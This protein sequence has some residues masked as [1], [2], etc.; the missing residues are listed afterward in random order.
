MMNCSA[1]VPAESSAQIR[2]GRWLRGNDSPGDTRIPGA[3]PTRISP[4]VCWRSIVALI[5]K[6]RISWREAVRRLALSA[7]AYT[8]I[9]RL[10]RT[11]A[12][13]AD[14]GDIGVEHLAEAVACRALDR[15]RDGI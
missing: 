13:L 2:R 7:R 9:L 15:G 4:G 6:D 11:I 1:S 10:A 5:L 12:D 8:R 3:A 14:S